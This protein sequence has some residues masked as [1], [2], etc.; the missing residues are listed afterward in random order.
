MQVFC[1][2]CMT[3]RLF[4]NETVIMGNDPAIASS[5]EAWTGQDKPLVHIEK[6]YERVAEIITY[7]F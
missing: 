6:N 4:V 3:V 5:Y 2:P 7:K 1:K